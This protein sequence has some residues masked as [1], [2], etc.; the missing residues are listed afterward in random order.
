MHEEV[1]K[2]I[3]ALKKGEE[4]EFDITERGFNV[5]AYYLNESGEFN[6]GE[7][8]ALI[9]IRYHGSVIK[10]F[11]YPGYKIWNMLRTLVIS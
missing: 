1:Y 3:C 4:P 10:S 9:E 5:K 8:N 7:W 6:I 11:I 2:K